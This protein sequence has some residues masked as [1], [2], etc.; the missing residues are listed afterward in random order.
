ME[1]REQES[2]LYEVARQL[3]ANAMKEAEASKGYIE[4]QRAIAAALT[5]ITDPDVKGLL[6]QIDAATSEK[7]SDELQHNESLIAEF[8][9]LT[10]IQPAKD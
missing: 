10:G 8:V 5:V 4:Q 3:Q 2:A 6:E 1:E 7:I 9:A